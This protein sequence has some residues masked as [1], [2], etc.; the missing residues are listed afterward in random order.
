MKSKP[1][2]APLELDKTARRHLFLSQGQGG[3]E[4]AR[5]AIASAPEGSAALLTLDDSAGRGSH[6]DRVLTETGMDTAFYVA[7]PEP[8]LW[9]IANRLRE[10]GVE[11][12]RIHQE[13]AGSMARRVY[14][15]HC[16]TMHEGV[17]TS[18]YR[19]ANCGLALT[20]RDHFSRPLG[21]YMG[22]I[23]DAEAP[24]EV[25]EPEILYR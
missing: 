5:R 10:A 8:F 9:Q 7:G 20:V 23:V 2:Y 13:L 14:C 12:R 16:R 22:V 24:G 3:L 1:V 21:A 11:N 18:I 6:L 17:T 19:C 25:P 15:V 4:A